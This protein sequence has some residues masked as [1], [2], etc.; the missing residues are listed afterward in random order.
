MHFSEFLGR[1]GGERVV[2]ITLSLSFVDCWV[3][4]YPS[5][6]EAWRRA[7]AFARRAGQEPHRDRELEQGIITAFFVDQQLCC[8]H[9]DVG[10]IQNH[11]VICT[12]TLKQNDSKHP[13][14]CR[15][16]RRD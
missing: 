4:A 1:I 12:K 14:A 15:T 11:D 10:Q 3:Q 7:A 16:G 2:P 8:R 13:V 5:L 6:A 9:R